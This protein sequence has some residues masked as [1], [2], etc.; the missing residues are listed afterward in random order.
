MGS[1][2][3]SGVMGD[4]SVG[5]AS[6]LAYNR[7]NP[8]RAC[9][10]LIRTIASTRGMGD[11]I[12]PARKSGMARP[13]E[14][15]HAKTDVCLID[16]MRSDIL[17]LIQEHKRFNPEDP[18]DPAPQLI[19]E[20]I[21]AFDYNNRWRVA[22]GETAVESKV[23][24]QVNVADALCSLFIQ[25]MP[26]IVLTGT[27]PTFYKIPVV[28]NLVR[29]VMP[30]VVCAHVPT[31]PRPHRR[32]SEGMKPLDNRQANLRCYEAFKHVGI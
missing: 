30:T 11:L 6:I 7:S 26:R 25:V 2:F 19:A 16:R 28:A 23:C 10:G 13:G 32:Q 18:R 1:I 21:A 9:R 14:W 5:D 20:A 8:E 12:A 29:D 27:A 3:A 17:L 15:K 24:R 22:A 4:M 31:L